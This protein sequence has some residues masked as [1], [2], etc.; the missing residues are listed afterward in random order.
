M[1]EGAWQRF[2]KVEPEKSEGIEY[3]QFDLVPLIDPLLYPVAGQYSIQWILQS[4]DVDLKTEKYLRLVDNKLSLKPEDAGQE[5]H[6][7]VPDRIIRDANERI[8]D[9]EDRL[10]D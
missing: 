6:L 1:R 10:N 7:R 4:N 3:W 2:I 9:F 8:A 5:V